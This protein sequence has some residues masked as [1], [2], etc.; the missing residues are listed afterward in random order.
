MRGAEQYLRERGGE[1]VF[2]ASVE[3]AEWDEETSQWTLTTRAGELVA[4]F[5]VLALPFEGTA[6]LLPHMPPADGAEALAGEDRAARAWAHL[7]RASVV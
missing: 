4:D 5:L 3:S 7:Q 1:V 6:K 2:N